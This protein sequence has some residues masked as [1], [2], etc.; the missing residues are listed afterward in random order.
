MGKRLV[1]HH[2]KEKRKKE[3]K[4]RNKDQYQLI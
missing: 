3:R 2:P 4:A 1:E